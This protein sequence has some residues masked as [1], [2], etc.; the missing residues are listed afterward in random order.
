GDRH[1][2]LLRIQ[3]PGVVLLRARRSHGCRV[4]LSPAAPRSR[5][6]RQAD[7]LLRRASRHH[8]RRPTGTAPRHA[9]VELKALPGS[10]RK[11][12]KL[13][14][15]TGPG[16]TDRWGVTCTDLGASVGAPNGSLVSV[17]GGTVSGN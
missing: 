13:A 15:I 7:R 12:G 14:D 4:D 5:T 8:R 11:D 16:I 3:G 1:G 10:R 17:V 2:Q 9:L 6:R